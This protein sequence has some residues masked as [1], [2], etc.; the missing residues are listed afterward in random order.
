MK[1]TKLESRSMR[2]I[3]FFLTV[4]A[5][6][7]VG[8]AEVTVDVVDSERL[9]SVLGSDAL[10]GIEREFGN[11]F[12]IYEVTGSTQAAKPP[13]AI[14]DRLLD[15]ENYC[16]STRVNRE[17]GEE[18]RCEYLLPSVIENQVHHEDDGMY[19]WSWVKAA[20][21]N[22]YAFIGVRSQE[23][24]DGSIEI[25]METPTKQR[26]AELSEKTGRGHSTNFGY[27]NVAWKF[28][29][30]AENPQMTDVS[31]SGFMVGTKWE[32]R[33]F[34]DSVKSAVIE[35]TELT[36]DHLKAE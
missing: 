15:F 7:A 13:V 34:K 19:V 29:V 16:R 1:R 32:S 31:I 4:L 8:W 25:E 28:A 12:V 18:V 3:L 22:D 33:N 27:T 9:V 5:F 10:D 26:I 11:K 23:N 30:N 6:H 21:F 35:S 20:I 24:E 36:M 14:Q 17:T 2:G